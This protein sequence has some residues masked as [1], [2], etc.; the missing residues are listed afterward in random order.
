LAHI[1]SQLT[2]TQGP[3]AEGFRGLVGYRRPGEGNKRRSGD[4]L[5]TN[6]MPRLT[7]VFR[8]VF[9]NDELVISPKTTAKDVEG[10]D[11]LM[12]VTLIVNVEKVFGVRFSSAEVAGL[13]N[14]GELVALIES[15]VRS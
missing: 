4:Y 7:E 10:W 11:S 1:E 9:D 2:T 12:H 5:M 13:K 15:R 6:T 3:Q 8:E 14:V